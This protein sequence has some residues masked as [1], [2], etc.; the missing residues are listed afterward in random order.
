MDIENVENN[1]ITQ[2]GINPSYF[3]D[4]NNNN[5]SKIDENKID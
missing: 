3:E 2:S 4:T 1:N 5:E